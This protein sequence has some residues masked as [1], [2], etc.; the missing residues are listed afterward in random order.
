MR[1]TQRI[2]DWKTELTLTAIRRDEQFLD[3][4]FHPEP[5]VLAMSAH[6]I[7]LTSHLS[8]IPKTM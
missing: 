6:S 7:S 5:H 8:V 1:E 2:L 3:H 4:L